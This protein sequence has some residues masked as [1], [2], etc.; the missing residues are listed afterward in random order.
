MKEQI[1]SIIE[2][3]TTH[4]KDEGYCIKNKDLIK[5]AE[6]L[7]ALF[8]LCEVSKSFYCGG[9]N[10]IECKEQCYGCEEDEKLG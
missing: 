2:N 4:I 1:L 8:A 6:K 10:T 3:T 7:D 5:L 9:H